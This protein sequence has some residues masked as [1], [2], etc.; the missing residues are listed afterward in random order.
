VCLG[1][2]LLDAGA[3]ARRDADAVAVYADARLA[4]AGVAPGATMGRA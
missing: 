2:A 1:S 3:I 4:E